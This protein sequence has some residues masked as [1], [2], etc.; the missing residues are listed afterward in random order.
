MNKNWKVC[1]LLVFF[2]GIFLGSLGHTMAQ[3]G[4]TV[5]KWRRYVVSLPNSIYSGNPFEV[6]LEG[7]FTHLESGTTIIMPGYYAGKD[8][9]KIGFMPTRT[10]TWTYRTSSSDSELDNVQGSMT[11]FESGLPGV[12]K[13]DTENPKKWK[14]ID[15]SYVVPLSF[16]F[17]VFQEDG[18]IERFAEIAQFLKDDVKGHMLEFTFRNEVFTPDWQAHQFAL[19][20]WDRLEERMEVLAESGLGIN[21]MFYSDDAQ[22][23]KWGAQSST[24]RLLIR[25]MVARLAAYPTVIFNTGIDIREYRSQSWVDWFGTQI[26]SLDPYGHPVSSR[27]GGGSGNTVMSGQTFDS[28]GD[29]LAKINDMISYFQISSVPVA[30]DDA[31]SENA[32]EAERRGK[33]FSEHD[34]RRAIWKTVMAG[35]LGAIIRGSTHFNEDRWFRMSNF[36]ED[37]ESEQFLRLINPFIETKLGK[38]FGTMVPDPTLISN[39]F[40]IAD[41]VRTKILYFLMGKNDRYDGGNGGAVLIKFSSVTGNYAGTWFNPRTGNETLLGILEGGT[42]YSITP[43][44]TDDWVLLLTQ[45]V[46]DTVPPSAPVNLRFN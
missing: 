37:L 11:A 44:S 46:P 18:A 19:S 30:M 5:G 6:E 43:P 24:E 17:D 15:G 28:R 1:F 8:T 42:D 9:W 7:I 20:L 21:F 23:P 41:P 31:W 33:N 4:D 2:A 45:S 13:A 26:R 40:A 34:I 3:S 35:G 16:R 10:G 32:P 36:E 12:L 39:G 22:T 25:Y 14:Y 27:Y 38:T 29:N